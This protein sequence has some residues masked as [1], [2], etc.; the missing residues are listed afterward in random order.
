MKT[1]TPRSLQALLP[2]TLTVVAML[3][4]AG[5]AAPHA[6]P[7]YDQ[8]PAQPPQ[9]VYTYPAPQAQQQQESRRDYRRRDRERLYDAPVT[10]VR[11]VL[12][13]SGQR[14]WIERENVSQPR[15]PANMPGAVV[16]AVVG[17]ILGHQIGG[18]SGRDIATAGGVVAG[19]VVGSNVG[20]SGAYGGTQTQDVQR[21]T[22]DHSRSTPDYWD[23]TYNFR[24]IDHRVQMTEPP[25]RTITVN[26]DGEPRI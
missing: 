1:H 26:G 21:C 10:S 25:G 16:G 23:V 13:Q 2:G 17:G 18:G 4:L 11:A 8:P 3:A 12:G 24:G 6:Y 9:Q 14:C 5:C 20:R 15:G 19:A 7:V 22:T